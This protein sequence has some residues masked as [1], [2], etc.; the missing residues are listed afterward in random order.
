MGNE[1]DNPREPQPTTPP[2]TGDDADDDAD[3]E[4]TGTR[5]S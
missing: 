2:D 1:T 3:D 4:G 5:A